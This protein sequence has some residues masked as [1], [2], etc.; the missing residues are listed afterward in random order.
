MAKFT[1]ELINMLTEFLVCEIG[2]KALDGVTYTME[3]NDENGEIVYN[4]FKL[5]KDEAIKSG[6]SED[7]VFRIYRVNNG[8]IFDMDMNV[9]RKITMEISKAVSKANGN[10]T[11]TG[12]L[13]GNSPIKRRKDDID[14]LA[15]YVIN[16][17][18][19]GET[20][21]EVA[22]FSRNSVPRIIINAYGL[23][24]E[25]IAVKY[26]AFAIRHWD[27]KELNSEYLIPSNIR[28]AK[29]EPIE[30]LPSKTGVRFKLYIESL[31]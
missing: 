28:V 27:L 16:Q 8:Y 10:S 7:E 3:F 29:I 15:K 21:I 6:Y 30:I 9:A 18:N 14:R 11:P 5:I 1:K 4:R 19:K 22:L 26:Q 23:N 20:E 12:D 13:I 31:N 24:N 17:Y 2:S 25:K